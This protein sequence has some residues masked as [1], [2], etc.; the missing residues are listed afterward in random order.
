MNMP[1]LDLLVLPCAGGS[2]NMYLRWRHL[3]PS[4]IRLVPVELPGR[5]MRMSEPF[6]TDIDSLVERLCAEHAQSLA[7][8]H[9]LFGHSMGALLAHRMAQRQRD[10]GG[11]LTQALFVS[12]SPSPRCR[13]AQPFTPL[14]GDEELIGELR[15]QGGTPQEVLRHAE[16]RQMVVEA[17]RADH[18]LCASHRYQARPPL[19]MPI[20]VLGGRS[21]TLAASELA[22]WRRETKGP[23]SLHW[24]DGGHFF[25]RQHE[26][27]VAMLIVKELVQQFS[28][29]GCADLATDE[30]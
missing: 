12:A 3:L 6:A 16:L 25:I 15:R 24:F 22:D 20:H 13:H 21:D 4:W 1:R 7:G 18:R 19:A 27:A 17:M 5:G 28:G 23:S 8:R 29:A 2:A 10:C 9:A 26:A 30:V 11:G 14:T